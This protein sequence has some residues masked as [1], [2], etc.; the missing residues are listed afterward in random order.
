IITNDQLESSTKSDLI[1]ERLRGEY[2]FLRDCYFHSFNYSPT[3]TIDTESHFVKYELGEQDL[4]E[5]YV[6]IYANSFGPFN[7]E[8]YFE[9]DTF[10]ILWLL[11]EPYMKSGDLKKYKSGEYRYLGGHNQGLEN[12]EWESMEENPTLENLI[13]ITQIILQNITGNKY[14]EQEA[15][16]HICILEVNH[17]PG[18]AFNSTNSY[19]SLIKKW[20]VENTSLLKVLIKFYEPDILIGGFTIGHFY[21]ISQHD[22]NSLEEAVKN[23]NKDLLLKLGLAVENI[24]QPDKSKNHIIQAFLSSE[25]STEKGKRV[26]VIDAYHPCAKCNKNYEYTLIDAE[27]DAK[28]IKEWMSKENGVTKSPTV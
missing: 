10:R 26:Y 27:A 21:N 1:M 18:L 8:K 2:V 9:K 13:H 25:P 23:G 3:V 15:M 12:C 24:K 20:A 14:S 11:K 28:E 22:I 5:D 17:F 16:N 4:V 19:D 7:P 6:K